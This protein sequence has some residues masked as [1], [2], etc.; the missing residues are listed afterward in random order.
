MLTVFLI[1]IL[2]IAVENTAFYKY[3]N[4]DLKSQSTL[5]NKIEVC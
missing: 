5:S 1:F 2:F 3:F 4:R